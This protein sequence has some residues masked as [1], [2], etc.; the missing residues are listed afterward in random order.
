MASN[1]QSRAEGAAA[2]TLPGWCASAHRPGRVFCVGWSAPAKRES[3]GSGEAKAVEESEP[4]RGSVS[5]ELPRHCLSGAR[6][7]ERASRRLQDRDRPLGRKGH[8]PLVKGK[9]PQR[10]G[11]AGCFAR[12]LRH[13]WHRGWQ[14]NM[15]RRKG[16]GI[17]CNAAVRGTSPLSKVARRSSLVKKTGGLRKPPVNLCGFVCAKV[18]AVASVL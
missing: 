16:R 3:A 10:T 6:C 8:E 15:E 14:Q 4:G 9:A 5:V 7:P 18:A 1:G 12:A 2:S 17:G 11:R 13:A